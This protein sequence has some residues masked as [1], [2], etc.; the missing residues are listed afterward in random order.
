MHKDFSRA[1]SNGPV[2]VCKSEA[3]FPISSF[4]YFHSLLFPSCALY[5]EKPAS[6]FFFLT[7]PPPYFLLLWF[8]RKAVPSLTLGLHT[9][10]SGRLQPVQGPCHRL[11]AVLNIYS[12]GSILYGSIHLQE[13]KASEQTV[14]RRHTR[15]SLSLLVSVGVNVKKR[16]SREV[17][18]FALKCR[19]LRFLFSLRGLDFLSAQR[20]ASG[21]WSGVRSYG[22]G[23]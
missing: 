11:H 3:A 15:A 6:L 1:A 4:I 22:P 23:C 16:G 9:G 19:P 21:H 7:P 14:A 10:L 20:S 5:K 17:V 13:A 8:I 2:P 12:F 18:L